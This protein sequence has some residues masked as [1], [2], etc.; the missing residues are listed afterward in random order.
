MCYHWMIILCAIDLK[1]LFMGM[2]QEHNGLDLA[3]TDRLCMDMSYG[4]RTHCESRF[5]W[6]MIPVII[7]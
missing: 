7:V 3:V 1:V 2:E 5:T 4:L 6:N